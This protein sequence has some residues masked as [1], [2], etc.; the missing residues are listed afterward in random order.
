MSRIMSRV[1]WLERAH[2]AADD[3]IEIVF[4]QTDMHGN[5]VP[6]AKPSSRSYALDLATGERQP[7]TDA[8]RE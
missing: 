1:R 3:V 6:G 4:I 8:E 5:P 2:Q 7:L